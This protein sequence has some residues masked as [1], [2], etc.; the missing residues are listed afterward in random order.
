MAD[1]VAQALFKIVRLQSGVLSSTLMKKMIK[2]TT[3]F[4]IRT[5]AGGIELKFVK[6]IIF[7][8]L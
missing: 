7:L 6:I 4:C 1:N 8:S 3:E 2:E 5:K